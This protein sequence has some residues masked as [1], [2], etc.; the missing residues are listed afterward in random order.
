[1]TTDDNV[2]LDAAYDD[3]ESQQEEIEA[4]KTWI[5]DG[6]KDVFGIPANLF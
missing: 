3:P 2:G 5:N 1:M 6:A 4:I